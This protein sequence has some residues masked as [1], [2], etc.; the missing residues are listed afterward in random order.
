MPKTNLQEREY[1][2]I[3]LTQKIRMSKTLEVEKTDGGQGSLCC[4]TGW[5]WKENHGVGNQKT[6][7]GLASPYKLYEAALQG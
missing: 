7:G 1:L 2:G 5:R 4:R 6:T 3:T